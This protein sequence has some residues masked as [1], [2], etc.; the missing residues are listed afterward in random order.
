LQR[1]V[2]VVLPQLR[3]A[4]TVNLVYALIQFLKTFTVVVVMTKGGPNRATNFVSYDAYRMF[5]LGD[6]GVATAM[7]TVLF[8][9]VILIGLGAYRLTARAA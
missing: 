2:H 8:A 4:I 6:Y 3:P 5:D 1:L 7:A 9:M